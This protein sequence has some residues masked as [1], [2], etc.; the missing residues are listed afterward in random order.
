MAR[1][2]GIEV[3]RTLDLEIASL[4]FAEAFQD[5]RRNNSGNSLVRTR[6]ARIALYKAAREF[7]K[8]PLNEI[9]RGQK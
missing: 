3:D 7:A 8:L 9:E 6:V 5:W 1:N 4:E 2:K